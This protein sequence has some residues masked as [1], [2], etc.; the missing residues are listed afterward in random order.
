MTLGEKIRKLRTDA[1]LSQAQL[2]E[3]LMVSRAAV[4]K[5]ENENGMPDVDNLKSLSVYFHCDLDSLLD[6]SKQPE[7]IKQEAS[8]NPQTFCGKSCDEC[9]YKEKLSCPGCKAG[10]GELY[11]GSCPIAKCCRQHYQK[12]CTQCSLMLHCGARKQAAAL[13]RKRLQKQQEEQRFLEVFR[14]Q[15]PFFGKWLWLL[16]WLIIANIIANFLSLQIFQPVP[17]IFY[18]GKVMH[19]AFQIAYVLIMFVLAK[20]NPRFKN[21]GTCIL[22]ASG[23]SLLQSVVNVLV[24]QLII[25]LFGTVASLIG[26][27]DEFTGYSEI[28]ERYH[29]SL[30]EKWS[31]LWKVYLWDHVAMIGSLILLLIFPV[32]AA[33]ILLISTIGLLV[34][35]I[36]KYVFLYQSAKYF[37]NVDLFQIS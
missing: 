14:R 30:S 34:I 7:Q 21:A 32:L 35:T 36:L 6:E 1:G 27:Y 12:S 18:T 9:T 33:F 22:I 17:M 10:P 13:S 11:H 3:A 19:I 4:A 26:T 37:R 24:L 15:V 25:L 2:A 31:I 20:E 16:F 28:L 8:S 23:I 5:W 29:D